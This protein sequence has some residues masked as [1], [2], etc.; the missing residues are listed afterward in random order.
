MDGAK[1]SK[2]NVTGSVS[3]FFHTNSQSITQKRMIP[4]CSN[5]V[6]TGHC[7][8]Q[9]ISLYLQISY[10]CHGFGVERS[11]VN[12]KGRVAYSSTARV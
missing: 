8:Y 5:L 11:K 3:V 10:K 9:D 7:L 1:K 4:K 12:V 6:G 2:V